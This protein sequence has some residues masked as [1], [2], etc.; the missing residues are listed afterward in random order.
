MSERNFIENF[1][2]SNRSHVKWL[3]KMSIKVM[4][5]I[6]E[7]KHID[8]LA[9]IND[10]PIPDASLA[11]DDILNWAQLHFIISM[12]YSTA[13]LQGAAWTPTHDTHEE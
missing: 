7:G 12:K 10:N 1:D 9:A 8:L 6:S 5:K 4:P 11:K 13:V 3:H 2:C